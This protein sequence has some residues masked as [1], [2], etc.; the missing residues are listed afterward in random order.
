MFIRNV[1]TDK[2]IE[3]CKMYREVRAKQTIVISQI[4]RKAKDSNVHDTED[5]LQ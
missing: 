1:I 4:I 5:I 2:V 3:L